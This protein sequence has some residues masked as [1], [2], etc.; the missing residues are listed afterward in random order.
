LRPAT[1]PRFAGAQVSG[2]TH[3]KISVTEEHIAIGKRSDCDACP[4]ALAIFEATGKRVAVADHHLRWRGREMWSP[5]SVCEFVRQFDS[6][7]PVG[8]FQFEL[9]PSLFGENQ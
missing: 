3:M 7:N 8:P 9:D 4:A 1:S 6:G 5:P 2:G